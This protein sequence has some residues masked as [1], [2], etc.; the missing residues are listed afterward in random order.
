M[1]VNNE[2]FKMRYKIAG[3]LKGS[4]LGPV[5]YIIFTRA[6]YSR[7][8]VVIATNEYVLKSL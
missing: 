7:D 2:F 3:I 1:K 4:V 5:L 6:I 8:D